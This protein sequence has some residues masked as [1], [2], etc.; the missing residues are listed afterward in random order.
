M[1]QTLLKGIAWRAA[2]VLVIIHAGLISSVYGLATLPRTD[3]LQLSWMFLA[4]GLGGLYGGMLLGIFFVLWPMWKI[5]Q[6]VRR[7]MR[8]REWILESLPMILAQLPMIL[9]KVAEMWKATHSA[10]KASPS[11]ATSAGAATK[12]KT[13]NP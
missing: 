5:Y 1:V 8:W 7:M 9:Q 11:P 13:P 2:F 4:W 12:D 10:P 6:Q 3:D